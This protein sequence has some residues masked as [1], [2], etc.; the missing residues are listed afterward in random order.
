VN[1]VGSPFSYAR[2]RD[3]KF[4]CGDCIEY[5]AKEYGATFSEVP[6]IVGDVQ[7]RCDTCDESRLVIGAAVTLPPFGETPYAARW[8]ALW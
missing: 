7:K 2:F 1:R 8:R 4:L 6:Q 3:A 5:G